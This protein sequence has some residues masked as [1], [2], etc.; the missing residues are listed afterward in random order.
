MY[1]IKPA[2]FT[3][4]E[5]FKAIDVIVLSLQLRYMA[6]QYGEANPV[7]VKPVGRPVCSRTAWSV[8]VPGR[9]A[10]QW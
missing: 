8:T 6:A 7:I 4:P 10:F 2:I 9:L 1:D 3:D 5:I